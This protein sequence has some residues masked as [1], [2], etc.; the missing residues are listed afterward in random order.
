MCC[1]Y[2]H[3]YT[4]WSASAIVTFTVL[5]V[6]TPHRNQVHFNWLGS[7]SKVQGEGRGGNANPHSQPLEDVD[8]VNK[9][10]TLFKR[11]ARQSFNFSNA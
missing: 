5:L 8:Q 3:S 6:T 4:N 1:S 9:L 2:V 10:N 7:N 11:T